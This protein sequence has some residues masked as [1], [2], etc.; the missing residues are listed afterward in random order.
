METIEAI[1]TRRSIRQFLDR[2]IERSLIE[3][4]ID[5]AAHAPWTPVSAPQPWAFTVIEGADKIADL[6]AKALAYARANRPPREGYGWL[7]N[8][9]FSVFHGAPVVVV[10]SGKSANPVGLEECTRAAQIIVIAATA[11]G[12]GS[13]WVGSPNLWLSAPAHQAELQ[14][15]PGYVP[16]A[17]IALGYPAAVPPAPRSFA[18]PV[19]WL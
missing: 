17:T 11:R 1:R 4:I 5:D 2:P 14:I 13:C 19:T 8:P 3:A 6:G 15:L 12:L 9:D 7:D 16:Y 10:I 18:P